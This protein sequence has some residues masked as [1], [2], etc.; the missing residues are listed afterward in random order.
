M[1]WH[2]KSW[3]SHG[4]RAA[5]P[6]WQRSAPWPRSLSAPT[7]S[8][9]RRGAPGSQE[10]PALSA[11]RETPVSTQRGSFHGPDN[12]TRFSGLEE[13]EECSGTVKQRLSR[14]CASGNSN[15]WLTKLQEPFKSLAVL[16]RR[17]QGTQWR[18]NCVPDPWAEPCR[19]QKLKN[20]PVN[21]VLGVNQTEA[22]ASSMP[23][24]LKAKSLRMTGSWIFGLTSTSPKMD[25]LQ[26]S[27][28]DESQQRLWK[29]ADHSSG[30]RHRTAT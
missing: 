18:L 1:R 21:S 15:L 14:K 2:K 23:A 3:R 6:R 28:V 17:E 7:G 29:P 13:P 19:E 20:L 30:Q 25:H 10:N 4:R 26:L 8:E 11:Q 5:W 22:W 12:R 9:T 16:S 27:Y 24:W